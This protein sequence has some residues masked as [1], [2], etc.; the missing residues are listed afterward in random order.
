MTATAWCR[1]SGAGSCDAPVAAGAGDASSPTPAAQPKGG[2]GLARDEGVA[3]TFCDEGVAATRD[4]N[5][6]K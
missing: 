2:F 1:L 4:G 6:A 5:G 3:F